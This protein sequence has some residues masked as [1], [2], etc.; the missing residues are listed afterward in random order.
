MHKGLMKEEIEVS[1]MPLVTKA[2]EGGS[3]GMK[4]QQIFFDLSS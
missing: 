3:G 2:G 1:H 4:L